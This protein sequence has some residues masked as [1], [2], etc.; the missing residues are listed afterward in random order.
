VSIVAG[1]RRSGGAILLLTVVLLGLS[2]LAVVYT[3]RK[4]REPPVAK[5]LRSSPAA[6]VNQTP[7]RMKFTMDA[8]Q[9]A[10]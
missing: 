9:A 7:F 5:P 3:L 2:L 4:R 6:R 1:S 8:F 10:S